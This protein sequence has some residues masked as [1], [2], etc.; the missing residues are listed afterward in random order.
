L[1]Y[2]EYSAEEANLIDNPFREIP[3][4]TALE[5]INY[6]H[7]TNSIWQGVD[8]GWQHSWL[9]RGQADASQPL[10]PSVWRTDED[11]VITKLLKNYIQKQN[12][13]TDRRFISQLLYQG[14]KF[15]GVD[16]PVNIFENVVSLYYRTLVEVSLISN[17]LDQALLRGIAVPDYLRIRDFLNRYMGDS[18]LIVRQIVSNDGDGVDKDFQRVIHNN[19][20]F[21]L[22][23]HH[24]I[25]T[26]LL[27]W[28]TNPY[29]AAFFAAERA[30]YR[31]EG[32]LAVFATHQEVLHVRRIINFPFPKSDN[33]YLHAQRGELTI[34]DGS[35]DFIYSGEYPTINYLLNRG[36][37]WYQEIQPIVI[38]LPVDKAP[39]LLRLIAIHHGI[40]RDQ[41]MPTFDNIAYVVRQ[42]LELDW[43]N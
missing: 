35:S 29:I 5:F 14:N 19:S 10:I 32:S 9:F 37:D 39:E 24:G 2:P 23:Q 15:Q 42:R 40:S 22:A 4:T 3:A 1:C 6:L 12:V 31:G 8:T 34:Y 20:F 17:L 16:V 33:P 7:L 43:S 30:L 18:M 11:S 26:R 27:D 13:E 21:A 28:T 38:T 25:P 36:S 41:L